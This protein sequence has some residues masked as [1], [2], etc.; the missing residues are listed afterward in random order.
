VLLRPDLSAQRPAALWRPLIPAPAPGLTLP[1]NP[2]RLEITAA[3]GPAALRLAVARLSVCVQDGA[4]IIYSLPAGT[5]TADGRRH[6]LIADLA[7]PGQAVYPLRLLAMSLAFT[8]PESRTPDATLTITSFAASPAQSG[9]FAVPFARGRLLSGWTP[10]VTS[11]V[12]A[13]A[14]QG[15]FGGGTAGPAGKPAAATWETTGAA[16]QALS[17]APGYGELANP[18]AAIPAG[19]TLTA[20]RPAIPVIPGIATRAYL[21]TAQASVGQTVSMSVGNVTIPVR[22][23]AALAAFPTVTGPGGALIVDQATVGDILLRQGADPAGVSEW[24]LRTA[25]TAAPPGLPSGSTTTD[26]AALAATLLGDPLSAAP[27][28]ALLAIAIAAA[29]LGAV[30][31]SVS[32]ITSVRDRRPQA[33]LLAAL[34]VTR[35]GQA[36]LLCLEQLLLSGP[37]AV[38]GLMLGELLAR[39]LIPAV[40]LTAAATAPVPPVRAELSWAIPAALALSLAALPVLAAA[41]SITRR[42]DPAAQLRAAESL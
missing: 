6:V 40:T 36:R 20:G 38:T 17:F 7:P 18:Q 14:T 31:F 4:G 13:D 42:P 33:A 16:G 22:I 19:L 9:A 15:F 3:L 37:A 11:P 39:L 35:A 28:Q 23:I 30:G 29:A 34:G 2:A 27:Q 32:V 1:G 24:W 41:F 10:A 8:M 21:A 12:L 5:L 25:G 26:S